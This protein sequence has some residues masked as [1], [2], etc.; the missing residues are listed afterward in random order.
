MIQVYIS[1]DIAD[2]VLSYFTFFSLSLN[3][4][5]FL[6]SNTLKKIKISDFVD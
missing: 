3:I 1:V 2:F 5:P 6:V 4:P